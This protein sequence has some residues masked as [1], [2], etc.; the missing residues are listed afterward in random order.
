[1]VTSLHR[2]RYGGQCCPREEMPYHC[3][4]PMVFRTDVEAV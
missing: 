4:A 2:R 3:L 1:M